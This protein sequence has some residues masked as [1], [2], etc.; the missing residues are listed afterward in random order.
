MD[1]GR[2][3]PGIGQV[4][5]HRHAAAQARAASRMRQW[6]KFGKETIAR[7]PMRSMCSSTS[8]GLARRLQRLRQDDVVE[9][10]VGIV[11]EIGVGVALDHR[12]AARDAFVDALAANLDAARRRRCA[13]RAAARAAR[14]RR[15]RRRARASPARP[16]RRRAGGRAR[17]GRAGGGASS[18]RPSRARGHRR[19]PAPARRRRGSRASSR[20]APARRAGRRR[21]RGRSRSRRRRPTRRRRSAHARWPALSAV[22]NSQSEVKETT[23]KRVFVPR[24]ALGEHAAVIGGEVE[25]VH[26]PRHVEIGVG[27]EAVDEGYALVAQ[28]AL[29]LEIGVEGE[30]RRLAVLQIAA[31]LAVQRRL[32]QI[33]DVRAPCAP[34]RGPSSGA[35]P[36]RDSARRA[37]RDR[38]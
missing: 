6:P 12:E 5:G 37:S 26:R 15:S 17:R 22:G 25:I 23:Q 21:G 18:R 14:R 33:G 27:V 3:V 4:L 31:E 34:R 2:V 24:K 28:I 36:P 38:P 16:C 11:D 1:V 10:V 19:A 20:T 35:C 30:G 29:D 13:R 8:A 32:R 7:R 9:G